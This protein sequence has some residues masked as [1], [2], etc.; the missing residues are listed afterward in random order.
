[1]DIKDVKSY[2]TGSSFIKAIGSALPAARS[3]GSEGNFTIRPS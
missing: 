2:L 1:M 3:A